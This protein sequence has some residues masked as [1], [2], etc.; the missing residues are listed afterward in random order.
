[1]GTDS[2]GFGWRGLAQ[3]PV[4]AS[5]NPPP[6]STD[7]RSRRFNVDPPTCEFL[8]VHDQVHH[9]KGFVRPTSRLRGRA[10]VKEGSDPGTRGGHVGERRA[11]GLS[12]R[13]LGHQS[14]AAGGWTEATGTF[15]RFFGRSIAHS[16]R[17]PEHYRSQK[18]LVAVRYSTTF[19]P[20]PED[21]G[22]VLRAVHRSRARVPSLWNALSVEV[23]F[24]GGADQLLTEDL[25]HG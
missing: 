22:M 25:Q 8:V 18:R 21:A 20:I 2:S 9:E 15:E 7:A 17:H 23:V 4:D 3:G 1:M 14:G 19:S 13:V 10:R 12:R 24:T 11:A 6:R 5:P 16:G